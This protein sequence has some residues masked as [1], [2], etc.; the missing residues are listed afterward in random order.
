METKRIN[1]GNTLMIAHRGLSGIERENTIAA[2]V[3]AANRSYFGIETD[4]HM[5][6]DGKFVVIHDE[7]TS[8]VAKANV[9][10]EKTDYSEIKNIELYDICGRKTRTDLRIPL[11]SEYIRICKRYEKTAVLELKTP[12]TKEQ[13]KQIVEIIK[14]EK[15]LDGVIFISFHQ[16][17]LIYVRELCPD[18]PAQ[19]LTGDISK[20]NVDFMKKYRLDLDCQH[21]SLTEDNVKALHGLG[22]KINAWTVDDPKAGERLALWGVDYITTNIL[23]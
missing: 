12:F 18:S 21:K 5:T 1:K 17:D 13:V 6:R 9:T 10:I 2:F 4:V 23:E 7:T 8:R 3:A 22:L 16:Q 14:S 20:E 15:Y 19:F 11:L